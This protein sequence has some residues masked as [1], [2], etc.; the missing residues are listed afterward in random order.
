MTLTAVEKFCHIEVEKCFNIPEN[1]L[2]KEHLA[3]E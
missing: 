1:I 2:E 3:E